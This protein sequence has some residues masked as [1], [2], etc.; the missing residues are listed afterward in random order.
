MNFTSIFT[1]VD[2]RTEGMKFLI[3][4]MKQ[5]EAEIWIHPRGLASSQTAPFTRCIAYLQSSTYWKERTHECVVLLPCVA[6]SDPMGRWPDLGSVP[7]NLVYT[8]FGGL[9]TINTRQVCHDIQV[10]DPKSLWSES[11]FKSEADGFA[12][13]VEDVFLDTNCPNH[14]H[15]PLKA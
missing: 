14:R 5:L 3:F 10:E 1:W 8:G 9:I 2:I 4:S 12:P 15:L 13:L 7:F 6:L 11:S